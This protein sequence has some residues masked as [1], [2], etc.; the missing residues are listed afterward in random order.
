MWKCNLSIEMLIFPLAEPVNT[1]EVINK[2]EI[3]QKSFLSA[4]SKNP[5][6]IKWSAR[7]DDFAMLPVIA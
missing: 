2:A 5:H 1:V 6:P 3:K 4:V 7:V